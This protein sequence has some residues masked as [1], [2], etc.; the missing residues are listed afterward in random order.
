MEHIIALITQFAGDFALLAL[1]GIPLVIEAFF[2][3]VWQPAGK[4]LNSLMTFIIAVGVTFA[5][6]YVS[7]WAGAGFLAEITKSWHVLLY[8]LGAGVMAN[9]T[10]VNIDFV[11]MVITF[12]LTLRTEQ[13][14]APRK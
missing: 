14:K 7:G 6:W 1:V 10:W 11:K 8:G 4:F 5:T 2:L 13:F 9:W 12:I 3:Y